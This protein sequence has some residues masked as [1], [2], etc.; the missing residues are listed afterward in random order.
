MKI[1][2]LCSFYFTQQFCNLH[3]KHFIAEKFQLMTKLKLTLFSLVFILAS[4]SKDND[5]P[6]G[7]TA[8]LTS[9]KWKITSSTAILTAA[10]TSETI[11]VLALLEPCVQDNYYIFGIDG[12]GITDEGAIKCDDSDPQTTSNGSWQ[13]LNND[14]QLQAGDASGNEV[15]TNIKQLDNSTMIL[16]YT[17]QYDATTSSITTTVYSHSN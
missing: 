5:T 6:Q 2:F 10:G 12:V 16:E 17:T 11:D 8:I 4:C 15:L 14:T 9:G 3:K 13:L 1:P 7:A